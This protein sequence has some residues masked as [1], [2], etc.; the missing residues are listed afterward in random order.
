MD[1]PRPRYSTPAP[2]TPHQNYSVCEANKI[3]VCS[4]IIIV[5]FWTPYHV[6]QRRG[7]APLSPALRDMRGGS[8]LDYRHTGIVP[9][10]LRNR[11]QVLKV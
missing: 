3:V 4:S 9:D 1:V 5:Q 6:M 8:E 11:F 7:E 2:S 10:D